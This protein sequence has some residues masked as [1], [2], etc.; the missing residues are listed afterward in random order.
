MW[1][2]ISVVYLYILAVV[3]PTCLLVPYNCHRIARVFTGCVSC[4]H[5]YANST[6]TNLCS[7]L[8]QY[9][10]EVFWLWEHLLDSILM[11]KSEISS[12]NRNNL[13]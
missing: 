13:N 10:Y 12:R 9:R 11:T 6:F 2:G 8:F 4:W 7:N 3:V 5:V 1:I